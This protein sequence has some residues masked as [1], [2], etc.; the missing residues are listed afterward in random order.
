MA[1][2]RRKS[3][4]MNNAVATAIRI[5]PMR[6]DARAPSATPAS[7]IAYAAR[8]KINVRPNLRDCEATLPALL[9]PLHQALVNMQKQLQLC[10]D[11]NHLAAHWK[12][13]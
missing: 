12:C 4:A 5:A 10:Q 8:L 1:R 7:A 11:A 9:V 2:A 3:G 6:A 13:E